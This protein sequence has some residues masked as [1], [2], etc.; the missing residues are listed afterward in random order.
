MSLLSK[1]V[2]KQTVQY[3][4]QQHKEFIKSS[5]INQVSALLQKAPY[6]YSIKLAR[7]LAQGMVVEGDQL[8]SCCGHESDES[9]EDEENIN[10]VGER[11][12]K[13]KD[14]EL[15]LIEAIN[16]TMWDINSLPDVYPS[17]SQS[18]PLSL[19]LIAADKNSFIMSLQNC[20]MK[21]KESV[22]YPLVAINVKMVNGYVKFHTKENSIAYSV[23]NVEEMCQ[24]AMKDVG[25]L[26]S[27]AAI[28]ILIPVHNT[29]VSVSHVTQTSVARHI[30]HL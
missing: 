18:S 11:Y 1:A 8:R 9:D 5:C 22:V 13:L 14:M 29:S 6:E 4:L 7:E 23:K 30:L 15:Y 20:I 10:A 17:L 16:G 2:F 26:Y 21:A 27:P 24:E 25:C 19:H 3:N 12:R 28:D